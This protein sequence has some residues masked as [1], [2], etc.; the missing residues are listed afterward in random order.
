MK[1]ILIRFDSLLTR[2]ITTSKPENGMIYE[3]SSN[4]EQFLISVGIS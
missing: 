1:F 4:A 3:L 2:S